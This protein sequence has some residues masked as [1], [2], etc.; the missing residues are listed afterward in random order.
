MKRFFPHFYGRPHQRGVSLVAG[1]FLL[2]LMS[3]LAAMLAN[4]MSITNRN[5]AADIGGSR[6]FQAA[7]AGAEWAMYQ[8]YHTD[9]NAASPYP[10]NPPTC[11]NVT[12]PFP[13]IAGHAL[14]VTCT[15]YTY[16]EGAHNIAVYD[17][18]STAT[19]TGV[20]APGIERQVK[21][22]FEQCRDGTQYGC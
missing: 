12:A 8:I 1:I 20:A 6:A 22:R 4:L 11:I 19:A 14:V 15:A 7:R 9:E 16:S 13:A 3:V 17:I 10:T 21:V 5:M 2:L 18:V